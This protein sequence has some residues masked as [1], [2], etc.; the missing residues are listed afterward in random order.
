MNQQEAASLVQQ[1]MEQDIPHEGIVRRLTAEL[2]AP[3]ALVEKFVAQVETEYRRTHPPQKDA[4]LERPPSPSEPAI[5]KVKLPPW[6]EDESAAVLPPGESLP[7]PQPS[8]Q[9]PAE[10]TQSKIEPVRQ[11]Q[12]SRGERLHDSRLAKFVLGE[13]M[14]NR[15]RSD[16]VMTVCE[17]TGVSWD[18]AQRFVGQVAVDNH[19]KI[20]LHRNIL[21]FPLGVVFILVGL[22]L[23]VTNAIGLLMTFSPGIS[24][25]ASFRALQMRPDNAV[26]MLL[27]GLA[28]IAGGVIGI[29]FAM[30][31]QQ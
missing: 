10:H 13:L 31:E 15:K 26:I 19:S 30:R 20:G 27:F 25:P 6:L 7:P 3:G 17:R 16:I 1:L 24:L 4:I 29:V 12:Q 9:T 18:E 21:V 28:L 2:R 11:D 22:Y 23:A 5:Q 8:W 14:K